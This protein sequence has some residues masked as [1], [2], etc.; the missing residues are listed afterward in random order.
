[1]KK[2]LLIV[3]L[4][5]G[6]TAIAQE[7]FYD[8]SAKNIAGEKVDFSIY[9]GKIVLIVNTASHCGLTPH[10]EGLQK[11]YELYGNKEFVVLGFPCNQFGAQEPGTAEEIVTFCSNNFNV[12]FPLFEKI[13]VNGE[14]ALPLYNYLKQVLPID[15]ENNDIR[16]NF[17]KFLINRNGNPI[18]RYAPQTTPEDLKIDIENLLA[19]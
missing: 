17:E 12:T 18:K 1:M 13:D 19:K 6:F 9:K 15:G 10:Y 4:A 14:N 16:W 2:I 11:L 5:V 3:A 7:N 8:F